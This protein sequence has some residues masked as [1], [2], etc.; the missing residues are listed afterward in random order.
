MNKILILK[1]NKDKLRLG[2]KTEV[3]IPLSDIESLSI[4]FEELSCSVK[5]NKVLSGLPTTETF[6]N[7]IKIEI[8]TEKFMWLVK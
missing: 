2:S 5:F 4:N 7:L 8:C 1:Q 3:E 6:N